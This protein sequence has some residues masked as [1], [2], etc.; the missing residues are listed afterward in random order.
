MRWRRRAWSVRATSSGSP[1]ELE[2]NGSA[3]A[4]ILIRSARHR[5]RPVRLL[6][7]GATCP[8]GVRRRT[9][10]SRQANLG[11]R[12]A[13]PEASSTRG[14]RSRRL[15]ARARTDASGWTLHEAPPASAAPGVLPRPSRRRRSCEPRSPTSVAPPTRHGALRRRRPERPAGEAIRRLRPLVADERADL[16]RR[17]E[18]AHGWPACWR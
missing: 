8:G 2:S 3:P 5:V 12:S 15:A 7:C 18:A 13:H 4:G 14:T 16:D 11:G 6:T 9:V 10:G 1:F 17:V